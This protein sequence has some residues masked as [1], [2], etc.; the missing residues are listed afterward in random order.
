MADNSLNVDQPL[1][2]TSRGPPRSY[3]FKKLKTPDKVLTPEQNDEAFIYRER[4][5][6]QDIRYLA[7]HPEVS[8]IYI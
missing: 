5:R 3:P 4:I 1:W 7:E 6:R 2:F 8:I